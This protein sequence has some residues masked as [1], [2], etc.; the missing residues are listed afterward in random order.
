M[1]KYG[2][3]WLAVAALA[4]LAVP[5][6]AQ[7]N[8][9]GPWSTA[10]G[11]NGTA[12]APF[13]VIFD[14]GGDWEVAWMLDPD[15]NE[16]NAIGFD[17]PANATQIVFDAAG[18]LYWHDMGFWYNDDYVASCTPDGEMRWVG[19][20]GDL[21][22]RLSDISPVVGQDAVYMIGMFDPNEY[23]PNDFC[24]G[25]TAQRI[26]ALNK[27]DG[28]VI[29]RTKLDNEPDCPEPISNNAQPNPAL[30]DGRLY[31]MGLPEVG[32]GVALY[33]IDAA[34][35]TILAN[36]LIPQIVGKMCG[37]TL[38]L[39]DKFGPGIHGLYVLTWDYPYPAEA[40]QIFG[41]QVNT[42]LTPPTASYAWS[43][44]SVEDGSELGDLWWGS[45][46]H[47]LYSETHDQIYVYTEENLFGYDAFSFDPISGA[48][49]WPGDSG[50]WWE[51]KGWYQTG[52]LDFDDTTLY[53]GSYDGGFNIFTDD[54][55]GN[56]TYQGALRHGVWDRPRQFFQLVLEED[57]GHTVAVTSTSGIGTGQTHVVMIDLDDPTEPANEDGPTY[58]DDIEVYQGPDANNLTLVWSDNFEAYA[59]GELPPASGWESIYGGEQSAPVVA[60]DPTGEGHGKVAC[61][62][63]IRP[64]NPNDPFTF[65][66]IYHPFAQTTG[67]VIVTKYKQWREDCTEIYEVLWGEDPNEYSRGYAYAYDPDCRLCTLEWLELWNQPNY[68]VP[69][70]WE[71]VTYTYDFTA[72]TSTV[73][74]D[75]REV[76]SSWRD[77][78][79]VLYPFAPT[80]SA[81]GFG[82]TMWDTEWGENWDRVRVNQLHDV[83]YG[84]LDLNILG[85]PMVGPDGKIYY[86]ETHQS[87]GDPWNPPN[88]YPGWLFALQPVAECSADIDGD[89]D[90][91]L[92][93]LQM[94][95]AAYGS[96]TGDPN[97][98]ANAD[99][100]PDGDVDLADLQF[101]LSDYGCGA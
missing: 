95:L 51:N 88:P 61:I 5:T 67:N 93:D 17:P 78:N 63:P 31:V 15:P 66:G 7:D 8:L 32:R 34:T 22:M 58:I 40:P 97:Y 77:P 82:F 91:D 12:R 60:E 74:I 41:L 98:N 83:R 68:Q 1:S 33:Q 86:F 87:G 90:T 53:T 18:N 100:E 89:G 79:G 26:F 76:T 10:F 48:Q 59:E 70:R 65:Q 64:S 81:A 27:A 75:G 38:L 35:G 37:N 16:P 55:A 6:I 23:D 20:P 4:F 56:L 28:S 14:V 54:G 36:N 42:N 50:G 43:S 45:F 94:L 71:Q 13:P 84:W 25:F 30:Y 92:A 24:L 85:G 80:D 2:T 39:P 47:I 52:A 44:S 49:G 101:L 29:W 62:D 69:E 21:G 73:N 57:T 99:F 46:A 9:D 3:V 96:H 19:P 11:V 72:E